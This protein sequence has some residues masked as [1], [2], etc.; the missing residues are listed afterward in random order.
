M[1]ASANPVHHQLNSRVGMFADR[2]RGAGGVVSNPILRWD[3][4]CSQEQAVDEE[5]QQIATAHSGVFCETL[6]SCFLVR[7]DP[8]F[9]T[10][11]VCEILEGVLASAETGDR[12][13][14]ILWENV[15]TMS[16]KK[17]TRRTSGQKI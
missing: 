6:L 13:A 8:C 10:F 4:R 14:V 3:V 16:T 11:L 5:P 15:G 1:K 2:L 12:F 9:A 7:P 17:V